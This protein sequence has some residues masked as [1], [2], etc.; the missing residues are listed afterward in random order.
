VSFVSLDGR[1]TCF[2]FNG[3]VKLSSL[4]W[5]SFT[6]TIKARANFYN[7]HVEGS[8]I[9]SIHTAVLSSSHILDDKYLVRVL[10]IMKHPHKKEW[11]WFDRAKG[12]IEKKFKVKFPDNKKHFLYKISDHHFNNTFNQRMRRGMLQNVGGAWYERIYPKNHQDDIQN[13]KSFTTLFQGP[14]VV[15]KR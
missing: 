3:C 14:V 10:D 1:L 5:S 4:L 13:V 9:D 11:A 7:L 2:V 15:E 8:S 6:Q 12:A